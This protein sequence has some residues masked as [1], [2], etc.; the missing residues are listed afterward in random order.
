MN[1]GLI[2][3]NHETASLEIREKLAFADDD[4]MSS[5]YAQFA[6]QF[7]QTELVIVSTC[8]RVELYVAAASSEDLP[9]LDD[10]ARFWGEF[11][12]LAPQEYQDHQRQ[13]QGPN[14]VNH[15]FDVSCSLNS[16][17]LGEA[18]IVNQ[19]KTAYQLAADCNLAG[20]LTHTLFQ[21][22]IRIA[23][24]VRTETKLSEGRISVASVAVGE[25][26]R[27][28]FNSFE[29]K[30]VLVIGA[31]EM[32]E[33]T[34]RY[35]QS[36]GANRIVVCNRSLDRAK[37]LA[38]D[39]SAEIHPYD[40]MDE[41]MQ[42]AD[43]IVSTT[44]ATQVIVD[45]PRFE[46][47]RK[48]KTR[49]SP[50]LII[51]LG[52]PRDFAVEVGEIDDNIFLFSI[53]DLEATCQRNRKKRASEITKARHLID[54][55]VETFLQDWHHRSSG[56]IIK[57]LKQSW[58]SVSRQELDQLYQKLPEISEQDKAHIERTVHRI[59][60]KLLHPPLETL[61]QESKSG[62]PHGLLETVRQL[63][64]LNGEHR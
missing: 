8:N 47:I 1:L 63:F 52:A 33:E 14:V 25:F 37:R 60:G 42:R 62:T 26:G 23:S 59:M 13:L 12:Q 9:S 27:N 5:A 58:D 21:S 36:E 2:Y 46:A 35:L 11:F 30:L 15:L 4:A 43:I 40:Q 49:R 18:Q 3:C 56:P 22:A 31:G 10:V 39:W 54:R 50:V 6:L 29:D 20:P 57:E 17:V 28:I 24:R 38:T 64:G 16:M 45:R 61:K 41:V 19:V 32:A 53:D 44:G 51:D 55:S 34:L 7:P 48:L